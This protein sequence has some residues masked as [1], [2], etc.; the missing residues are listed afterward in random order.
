[1]DKKTGE[2]VSIGFLRRTAGGGVAVDG[3]CKT[4]CAVLVLEDGAVTWQPLDLTGLSR[5]Q[6]Q[7]VEERLRQQLRLIEIRRGGG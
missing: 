6:L 3:N 2:I 1:V 7:V 5:E 4:F